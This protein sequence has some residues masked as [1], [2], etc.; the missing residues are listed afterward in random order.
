MMLFDR[1]LQ[2]RSADM[3]L[4]LN[5]NSWTNWMRSPDCIELEEFRSL[6]G[7]S[8]QVLVTWIDTYSSTQTPQVR[9]QVWEVSLTNSI[10]SMQ[11]FTQ[12]LTVSTSG[13]AQTTVNGNTYVATQGR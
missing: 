13:T 3:V 10:L 11:A 5:G 2:A 9:A 6:G 12:I 8:T 4:T 1:Y 7:S